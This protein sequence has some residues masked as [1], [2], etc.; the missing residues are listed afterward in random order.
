MTFRNL[1]RIL[2]FEMKYD[3][4]IIFLLDHAALDPFSLCH[5]T[6]MYASAWVHGAVDHYTSKVI[7]PDLLIV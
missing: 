4:H 1:L 7:Q 2:Q 5:L 6:V 3:A